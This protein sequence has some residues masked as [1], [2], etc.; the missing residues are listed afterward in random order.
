M[1]NAE[2]IK[3]AEY[4]L[5]EINLQ[6]VSMEYAGALRDLCD[7]VHKDSDSETAYCY[8]FLMGAQHSSPK[9]LMR[10]IYENMNSDWQTFKEN[11]INNSQ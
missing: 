7:Y 5:K 9:N 11:L 1:N 10:V 8:G 6:T 2:A 4:L 3:T